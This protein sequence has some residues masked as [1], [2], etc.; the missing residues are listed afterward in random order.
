MKKT[1]AILTGL[2]MFLSACGGPTGAVGTQGAQSGATGA[3]QPAAAEESASEETAAAEEPAGSEKPELVI[4]GQ[5]ASNYSRAAENKKR[6]DIDEKASALFAAHDLPKLSDKDYT[7]MVYVVGSNLESHYGAATNDINEMIASGLDYSKNNLLVYT[8]GSKRWTSDISNKC[9]SVINMANGEE[10]EV[11][12]QTAETADMGAAQTLSEF[13]NYC[14]TNFPAKHYGLVLWDHGAGPLWGYGS[15]ELYEND[16]LLFEEL[17]SAMDRTIFT[18]GKKLD[19]V[20]FDACLMGSIETANLWKD[21]A[22]YLVGSEELES[23]RGWD[24]SFLSTL[25]STDDARTIVSSIVDSYG[26]Y[27]EANKSEFF[28]PDVTL[29]AMDLSKTDALIESMGALFKIRIQEFSSFENYLNTYQREYYPFV[30]ET[31]TPLYDVKFKTP[32]AL[33]FGNEATGLPSSIYNQNN[34]RIEQ[35]DEVDSLNLTTSIAIGLYQ[36]KM[37]QNHK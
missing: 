20:G 37:Q 34:V 15:D 27:Y 17:R 13:V 3:T 5:E 14:T 18:G 9:N 11:T 31:S 30:L 16:S 10:L 36:L 1:I 4:M 21:Y 22:Q 2:V 24:Y 26:S 29:A 6:M 28:N 23:G 12:A 33:V 7:I 25:N 32:C 8:G 19:W 35:S